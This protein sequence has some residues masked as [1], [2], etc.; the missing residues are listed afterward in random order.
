MWSSYL[1]GRLLGVSMGFVIDP[2]AY[3]SSME[4]SN[5]DATYVLVRFKERRTDAGLIFGKA[6]SSGGLHAEQHLN[7]WCRNANNTNTLQNCFLKGGGVWGC[8]CPR[9]R[10]VGKRSR[11]SSRKPLSFFLNGP[12]LTL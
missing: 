7:N 10:G 2:N 12:R 9:P 6:S 5:R 3:I 8:S 1:T 4:L 11:R